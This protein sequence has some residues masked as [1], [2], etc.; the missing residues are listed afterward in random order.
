[1]RYDALPSYP[2]VLWSIATI[3]AI[4][5]GSLL[6]SQG[7]PDLKPSLNSIMWEIHLDVTCG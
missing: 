3:I 4:P 5:E 2:G 6:L 7:P 1:M